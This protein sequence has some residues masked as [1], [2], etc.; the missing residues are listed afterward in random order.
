MSLDLLLGTPRLQRRIEGELA[1]LERDREIARGN[2]QLLREGVAHKVTSLPA[3]AGAVAAGFLVT[4]V[5]R[6]PL[7]GPSRPAEER[8]GNAVL[9]ASTSLAWQFAMPLLLGWIQ[10]RFAPKVAVPVAEPV[11]VPVP[12]DAQGRPVQP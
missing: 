10:T 2:T 12:V 9:N 8:G 5:T 11:P 6:A 1:L 3:L 7:S 4:K